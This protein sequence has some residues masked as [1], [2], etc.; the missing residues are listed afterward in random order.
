MSNTT[1]EFHP[2]SAERV[3]ANEVRA[4]PILAKPKV[5]MG[6]PNNAPVTN[7]QVSGSI[8]SHLAA[9]SP[10]ALNINP[11]VPVPPTVVNRGLS[12]SEAVSIDLPSKFAF[13]SFKDLYVKPFKGIHL[14][15]LS[16]AHEE[17]SILPVLEAVS[18]V[19]S[20][21]ANV[22]SEG[23]AF[24]L[25]LPDFYFVMYWLRINSF[26]KSIYTHTTQCNDEKHLLAVSKG[27]LSKES[28]RISEQIHKTRLEVTNLTEMPNP[29]LF[30]LENPDI[31]LTPCTMLETVELSENDN[32][33]DPEFL[34]LAELACYVKVINK[35]L[36]LVERIE[37]IKD[38]SPDD[39][40]LVK[41]YGK[42][43]SEYGVNE[44]INVKCKSCGV[45]KDTKLVLSPENFLSAK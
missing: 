20:T 4:K 9:S 33:R 26:T 7:Q 25:T 37:I 27:T 2:F 24:K 14:A 31:Y 39:L 28:L 35:D 40:N 29:E 11:T 41:D 6:L 1:S 5:T 36:T 13:Y 19:L 34:Y 21:S 43:I 18:S 8:V 15:K 30:Q 44:K 32:A 42:A 23:L 17:R 38:M 22:S 16:R 3:Q 10:V 45:A 12:A